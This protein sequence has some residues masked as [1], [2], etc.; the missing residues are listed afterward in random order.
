MVVVLAGCSKHAAETES[1][2]PAGAYFADRARDAIP[3]LKAAIAS[4]KPSDAQLECAA[5]A[6]IG[7]LKKSGKHAA[8]VAELE[9][10]CTRDLHVAII[11]VAVEAAEA[12]RKAKPNEQVLSECFSGEL[13]T[14]SNEL[15]EHGTLD[16]AKDLMARF[17]AVCPQSK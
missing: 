7:D 5:M 13:T 9:P 17:N 12:A 10:L 3:K 1:D 15:K 4:K 2:D 6:G 16:A 11:K 8:L 14:A